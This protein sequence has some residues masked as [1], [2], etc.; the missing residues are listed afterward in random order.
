MHRY[1]HVRPRR[2]ARRT[3][4][5][6]ALAALLALLLAPA[7]VALVTAP[8]QAVVC[9][10]LVRG[11]TGEVV[12]YVSCR[13]RPGARAS[14]Y[15]AYRWESACHASP[16]SHTATVDFMCNTA[17][18]AGEHYDELWGHLRL[19]AAEIAAGEDEWVLVNRYCRSDDV[20]VARAGVTDE[21][22]LDA[23]QRAGL[24]RLSVTTQP[25]TATLVG[26]PTVLSTLALPFAT[27]LDVL[28][29]HIEVR[30]EATSFTWHHGDGTTQT[31]SSPGRP[32]PATD[33][34]HVY[35]RTASAAQLYVTVTWTARARVDGGAWR[36]LAE[37]L[38]TDGP[39]TVLQVDEATPVLSAAR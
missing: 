31:T 8:A 5:S 9:A 24:P 32:Y 10:T 17:C 12:A 20:V 22:V 28:G 33:V 30:A 11:E 13:D 34:T 23:L 19:T 3:R 15:D 27:E 6:A 39:V 14:P 35:A 21:V 7:T 1:R 2:R 16:L 37:P 18:P 25:A 29:Q 38:T 26:L 4:R 36:T